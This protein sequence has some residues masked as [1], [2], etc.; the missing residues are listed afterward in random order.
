MMFEDVFMENNIFRK[1][2]PIGCVFVSS[3]ALGVFLL[4]AV[5][6]FGIVTA[7]GLCTGSTPVHSRATYQWRLFVCIN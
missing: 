2:L 3:V 1:D 7:A 4:L 5:F 6:L